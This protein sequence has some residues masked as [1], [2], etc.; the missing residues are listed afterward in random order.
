MAP[1]TIDPAVMEA[2][3]AEGQEEGRAGLAAH[4]S[5]SGRCP[6]GRPHPPSPLQVRFCGCGARGE[7]ARGADGLTAR[8]RFEHATVAG[9][10]MC[11]VP[12]RLGGATLETALAMPGAERGRGEAVRCARALLSRLDAGERPGA[13]LCLLGPTGTGKSG[14]LAGLTHALRDR[15]HPVVWTTYA[16]LV[17]AVRAKY[18]HGSEASTVIVSLG[19]VPILVIDELGDPFRER[20]HEQESEDRRRILH[21][22]LAARHAALLPTLLSAN[23]GSLAEMGDQFDPR[24]SSR[25][26]EMCVVVTVGGRDLRATPTI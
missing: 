19:R 26:T 22:V 17:D 1:A 15:G 6:C 11:R 8:E 25:V 3:F 24:V 23:Y 13:G 4:E 14:V 16:S 7:G 9:W 12:D 20:G 2:A 18:G 10:P 5:E 21:D